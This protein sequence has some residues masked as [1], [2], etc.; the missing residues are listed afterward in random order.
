MSYTINLRNPL[1]VSGDSYEWIMNI[2]MYWRPTRDYFNLNLTI[3]IHLIQF[4][5]RSAVRYPYFCKGLLSS[6]TKQCKGNKSCRYIVFSAGPLSCARKTWTIAV[7]FLYSKR[8]VLVMAFIFYLWFY[9]IWT[10]GGE[11]SLSRRFVHSL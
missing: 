10:N 4:L 8:F 3:R 7:V 5:W 6:Q 9:L 2:K 1:G 11:K